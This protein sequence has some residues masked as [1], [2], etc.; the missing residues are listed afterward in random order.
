[1]SEMMN[2]VKE[3]A[4]RVK[5]TQVYDNQAEVDREYLLDVIALMESTIQ[6]I[7]A[8]EAIEGSGT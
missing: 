3:R 7:T 8:E 2:G 4:A 1:M 6:L 5:F